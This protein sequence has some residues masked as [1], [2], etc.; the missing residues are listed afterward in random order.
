[1]AEADAATKDG[2]AVA[3]TVDQRIIASLYK[4]ISKYLTVG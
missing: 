3:V 4:R 1:M 2:F